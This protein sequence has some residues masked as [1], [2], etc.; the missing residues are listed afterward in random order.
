MIKPML[1]GARALPI[2]QD[3]LQRLPLRWRQTTLRGDF[4]F[5]LNYNDLSGNYTL[6]IED[7]ETGELLLAPKPLILGR[8][9][10]D[11][12]D[13]P[14]LARFLIIPIDP[15][16]QAKEITRENLGVDVLLYFDDT[17]NAY[18]FEEAVLMGERYD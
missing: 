14:L 6:R 13:H 12:C 4:S 8:D 11:T 10:L 9:L 18:T 5:E 2:S 3:D 15:S 16:F 17:G 1:I 7:A